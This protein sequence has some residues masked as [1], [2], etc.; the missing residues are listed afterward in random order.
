MNYL[1][2]YFVYLTFGDKKQYCT[3]VSIFLTFPLLIPQK[4]KRIILTVCK[5]QIKYCIFYYLQVIVEI[6]AS[7][8]SMYL[9]KVLQSRFKI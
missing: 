1:K 3:S 6:Y 2:N 4:Y 5:R 7:V 9:P 8:K